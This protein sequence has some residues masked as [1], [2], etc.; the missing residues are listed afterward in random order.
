VDLILETWDG[1]IAAIE[2]KAGSRLRGGDLKGLR[3]LRDRLG[4]RFLGGVVLNLGELSF[5]SE[6]RIYVAPLDRLWT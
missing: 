2:V 4:E 3:M 6:D 1:R 5:R